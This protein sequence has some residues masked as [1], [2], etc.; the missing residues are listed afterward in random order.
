ML[1]K[2]Y[3]CKGLAEKKK[4]GRVSQGPWRQGELAGGKGTLSL[5]LSLNLLF[6]KTR[7]T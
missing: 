2:D 6:L 1:H 4:S 3:N 5:S 7:H